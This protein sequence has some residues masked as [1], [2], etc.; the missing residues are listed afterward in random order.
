MGETVRT[1]LSHRSRGRRPSPRRHT[2]GASLGPTRAGRRRTARFRQTPLSMRVGPWVVGQTLHFGINDGLMVVFFFVVG[3]EIRREL[4]AGELSGFAAS[5]APRS[6]SSGGMLAPALSTWRCRGADDADSGGAFRWRPTSR[7]RWASSVTRE[8]NTG[9]L[10][11]LLLSPS[12]TTSEPSSS[13]RSSTQPP[14]LLRDCSSRWAASLA[15]LPGSASAFD[16]LS[17]IFCRA[18]SSGS[19][20]CVEACIPRSRG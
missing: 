16:V 8:A 3:L 18:P 2:R 12:S 5:R 19:V 10:R 15:C 9:A 13:L 6:R 4:Y 20:Y 7:S 14:C 11:F 17:R 1:V